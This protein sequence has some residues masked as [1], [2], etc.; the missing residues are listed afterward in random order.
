VVNPTEWTQMVPPIRAQLRSSS[1]AVVYAWTIPPPARSLPP[2][3]SAPFNSAELDVPAGGDEL[4]L[5]LGQP[6]A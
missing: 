5:T 1:G 6:K 3:G 2:G 4:T